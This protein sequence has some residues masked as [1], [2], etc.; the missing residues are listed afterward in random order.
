[1][2]QLLNACNVKTYLSNRRF[3]PLNLC[4]QTEVLTTTM[5]VGLIQSVNF[6]SINRECLL[7]A[8]G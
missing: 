8:K 7:T 5:K 3:Q 6:N 4:F 1:M 2:L